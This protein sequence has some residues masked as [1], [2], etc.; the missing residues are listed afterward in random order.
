[1]P[2]VK[3]IKPYQTKE[4]RTKIIKADILIWS[5]LISQLFI[6]TKSTDFKEEST[7][8]GGVDLAILSYR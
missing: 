4:I 2:L 3:E 6:I 7:S 8:L 1:M 5:D